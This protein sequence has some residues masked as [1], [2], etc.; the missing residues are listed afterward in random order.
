MK[1]VGGTARRRGGHYGEAIINLEIDTK[2]KL[3]VATVLC[4]MHIFTT[5]DCHPAVFKNTYTY[6]FLARHKYIDGGKVKEPNKSEGQGV[7]DQRKRAR[8]ETRKK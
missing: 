5:Y 8:F 6:L 4:R 1:A 2:Q 3:S 7:K